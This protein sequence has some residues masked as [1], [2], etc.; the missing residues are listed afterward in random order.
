MASPKV[1][2][3]LE[4]PPLPFMPTGLSRFQNSISRVSPKKIASS[5]DFHFISSFHCVVVIGV[6]KIRHINIRLFPN[7]RIF[8]THTRQTR[9]TTFMIN[10]RNIVIPRRQI[11]RMVHHHSFIAI[12]TPIP[13][14]TP[15]PIAVTIIVTIP[16]LNPLPLPLRLR[17]LTSI[18]RQILHNISLFPQFPTSTTPI[19][20]FGHISQ[21]HSHSRVEVFEKRFESDGHGGEER[22][23]QREI[24]PDEGFDDFYRGRRG[25]LVDVHVVGVD[26]CECYAAVFVVLS[27]KLG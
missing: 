23:G 3:L 25:V 11:S 12:P 9:P 27:W 22:P 5:A 15:I 2:P 20:A 16:P 1:L 7:H 21:I 24:L 14:P 4:P 6:R 19:V 18:R 26:A 10:F 13:T 17:I 8:R